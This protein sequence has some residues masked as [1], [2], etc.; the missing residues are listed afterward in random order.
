MILLEAMDFQ[1][2]RIVHGAVDQRHWPQEGKDH[3]RCR[4]GRRAF[5]AGA[6]PLMSV[7]RESD[8]P[9]ENGVDE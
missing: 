4:R 7:E 8:V 2:R 9:L 5:M 3:G 1:N 6:V